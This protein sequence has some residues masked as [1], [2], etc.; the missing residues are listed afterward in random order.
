MIGKGR[1]KAI[2]ISK[3]RG[4]RKT[5]VSAAELRTDFGMVGDAHAG[6]PKR[7]VSLLA[8]E[9][10]EKMIAAGVQVSPGDFAENIT[11]EG[12]DL[13]KLS[14]GHK[15]KLGEHVELQIVELGKVCHNRC[16]IFEQI[17]DCVMPR[18]GVFAKVTKPGQITI[19][20][21]VELVND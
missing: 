7:Q 17:G 10:I 15:L 19:G 5:N 1:I 16:K 2:S 8:A 4:T 14:I 12:I 9:S 6:S 18:E 20:D 11:T 21:A 13:L 3:E